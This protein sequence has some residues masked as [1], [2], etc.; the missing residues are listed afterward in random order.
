MNATHI[1]G[2]RVMSL[3][4]GDEIAKASNIVYSTD[5]HRIVAITVGN[6]TSAIPFNEI[7]KIGQDA[8]MVESEGAI[9][10]LSDMDKTV[11]QAVHD[12]LFLLHTY[13][14][15]EEGTQVGK[16]V[17][18][19]FNP[20]TGEIDELEITKGPI[21]DLSEGRKKVKGKDIMRIGQTNTI[22][23]KYADDELASQPKG[24]L[25]G[26]LGGMQ[27]RIAEEKKNARKSADEPHKEHTQ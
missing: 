4:L 12:N 8:I 1:K 18:F 2:L 19:S 14:I 27:E 26:I 7:K 3:R 23:S 10:N 16:V 21:D 15:T 24:G 20:S 5:E 9:K 6:S 17:N 11:Q 22:V 13:V 25:Q